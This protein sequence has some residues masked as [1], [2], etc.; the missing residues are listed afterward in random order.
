MCYLT[1]KVKIIFSILFTVVLHRGK[2]NYIYCIYFSTT[3]NAFVTVSFFAKLSMLRKKN[4]FCHH[5]GRQM[6]KFIQ[7]TGMIV[8][9]LFFGTSFQSITHRIRHLFVNTD[10]ALYF[11]MTK[12]LFCDNKAIGQEGI[13][14]HVVG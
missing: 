14:I 8:F 10:L 7:F 6:S 13:K 1:L 5:V 3:I 4:I 11:H 2:N 9:L 12:F